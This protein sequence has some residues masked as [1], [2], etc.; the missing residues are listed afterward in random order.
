MKSA[1]NNGS[2]GRLQQKELEN[3]ANA[4]GE[5]RHS[6]TLRSK[7]SRDPGNNRTLT[8]KCETAE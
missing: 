6:A 3:R 8:E 5:K 4:I 7:S 1:Q 2:D